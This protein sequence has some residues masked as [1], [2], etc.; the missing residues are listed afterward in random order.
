[1]REM[2]PW[3]EGIRGAMRLGQD[4]LQCKVKIIVD[5]FSTLTTVFS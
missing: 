1:M 2:M 4:D 5:H 3:D